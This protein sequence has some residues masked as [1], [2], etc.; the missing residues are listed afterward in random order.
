MPVS[1]N[2]RMIALSRRSARLRPSHEAT[3][4]RS[5][6]RVSTGTGFSGTVGGFMRAIGLRSIS[7]SSSSHPKNCC[8]ARYRTETVASRHRAATPAR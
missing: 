1:A 2:S 8:N 7:S 4:L 6:S 5:S 3:S